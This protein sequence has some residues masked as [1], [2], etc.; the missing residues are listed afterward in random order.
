MM[1]TW[2]CQTERTQTYLPLEFGIARPVLVRGSWGLAYPFLR[3]RTPGF[4][5]RARREVWQSPSSPCFSACLALR[6]V[7]GDR[8]SPCTV[9]FACAQTNEVKLWSRQT[10][11]LPKT[12]CTRVGMRMTA[13]RVGS[14][15]ELSWL[16][17]ATI[18]LHPV[19]C[20]R[21]RT[22]GIMMRVS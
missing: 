13:R 19:A 1:T 6:T 18:A 9:R 5:A 16:V 7:H 17:G 11:T 22:L 2:A 4:L 8:T 20:A 12:L 14:A 3:V 15:R 21:P 10:V